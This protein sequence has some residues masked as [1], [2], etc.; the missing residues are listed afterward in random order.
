MITIYSHDSEVRF[1]TEINEGSRR[2]RTIGG[3]DY[4]LLKFSTVRPVGFAVGDYA[5]VPGE[6]RMT[7][8]SLPQPS[9]NTET[10]GYDYQLRLEPQW[11]LMRNRLLMLNPGAHAEVEFRLTDTLAGHMRMAMKCI[12]SCG[13][14]WHDPADGTDIQYTV[15]ISTDADLVAQDARLISYSSTDI[16]SGL[17]EM[18][19]VFECEVW[20]EGGVI[21]FGRREQGDIVS[22]ERGD[23]VSDIKPSGRDGS[24]PTRLYAFG[25][26]ENLPPYY[27]K[28][29]VFKATRVSGSDVYD[30]DHPLR[31]SMFRNALHVA[32]PGAVVK[33][34]NL[35][36]SG[37]G[38]MEAL[39]SS[40]LITA[41]QTKAG[42]KHGS[43]NV[44]LSQFRPYVEFNETSQKFANSK[45]TFHITFTY[46][47]ADGNPESRETVFEYS[48]FPH[49]GKWKASWQD[50]VISLPVDSDL[51]IGFYLT[52]HPAANAS[53]AVQAVSYGPSLELTSIAAY[54]SVQG[55]TLT[56]ADGSRINGV[57]FNVGNN[58]DVGVI[59]LRLPSGASL[60]VG[61][62]FTLDGLVR[63]NIPGSWFTPL[64]GEPVVDAVA[65]NRLRL[66]VDTPYIDYGG[67]GAAGAIEHVEIFDD[68]YPRQS[69]TISGVWSYDV[70]SENADG[71]RVT[72]RY[73]CIASGTLTF[74]SDFVIPGK[75]GLRI[76]FTSGLL[77]GM[78]F[79]AEWLPHGKLETEH[80]PAFE[81]VVN[82]D[83]G[84][85][86]PNTV[87]K[88]AENDSFLLLG[89]ADDDVLDSLVAAAELELKTKAGEWM[90][91]NITNGETY[92]CPMVPESANTWMP[93][94]GQRI[95]LHEASLFPS[96]TFV[97]RVIGLDYALDIPYD[98]P[99]VTVGERIPAKRLEGIEERL[100]DM[101][102][103]D[104]YSI[105]EPKPENI[106]AAVECDLS[107]QS[108]MV[109]FND[110]G[111][112][113]G[114]LPSTQVQMWVDGYRFHDYTVAV[115]GDFTG[116]GLTVAGETVAV[117]S[118]DLSMPA[119]VE[120][121]VKATVRVGG[122]DVTRT[123]VF[124]LLRRRG[125]A[126][127]QLLPSDSKIRILSDGSLLPESGQ[128]T[129]GVL[130][131]GQ[132]EPRELTA[133]EMTDAGLEVEWRDV[134]LIDPTDPDGGWQ[135]GTPAYTD[136]SGAV[137]LRLMQEGVCIDLETV[138]LVADGRDGQSV[139]LLDLDNEMDSVPCDSDAN[140]VPASYACRSGIR[141][142][143]GTKDDTAS[144]AFSVDSTYGC[145]ASI[146]TDGRLV[147]TGFTEMKC[148]AT[149]V[150]RKQG[151]ADLY[152]TM[153][154]NKVM[155]E[156]GK[157]PVIYSIEPTASTISL[158]AA[159]TMRPA[160]I[161]ARVK[162]VKGNL[163]QH[164][165][166]GVVKYLLDDDETTRT[167]LPFGSI[168]GNTKRITPAATT[169]SVTFELYDPLGTILLDTER[170]PVVRDG[171][172]GD[173]T[174]DRGPWTL[175]ESY[176]AG[177][178]NPAT[179]K[180]EISDAWRFGSR[181]RC[182]VTAVAAQNADGSD[183]GPGLG[184]GWKFISGAGMKLEWADSVTQICLSQIDRLDYTKTVVVYYHGEDVTDRCDS[185]VWGRRTIDAYG[186]ERTALDAAW[187]AAQEQ[188]PGTESLRLDST[189]L[190]LD[191]AGLSGLEIWCD[192]ELT[193]PDI[194][195]AARKV[196]RRIT[197]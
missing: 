65:S 31:L 69:N 166:Y 49:T 93:S 70:Q 60:A 109:V 144:W 106:A 81:I 113:V 59:P 48:Y 86:L 96:G 139:Y 193:D 121:P 40:T 108:D 116:I 172:D 110:F 3:D 12:A 159:G 168:P 169:T 161:G 100:R 123:M 158:D 183:N 33:F 142:F 82:D 35:G 132:G 67:A 151:C 39:P 133:Q 178:V 30:D 174:A 68:V 190:G 57:A 134:S 162:A 137:Q 4:A 147:M 135:T 122:R 14:T 154:A 20:I 182:P 27:R 118:A 171:S 127:F 130:I 187:N 115:E 125:D 165:N 24:R 89:W 164:L 8:A 25:G 66:P 177:D 23:N 46:T 189:T 29:M 84:R 87:L 80:T 196:R 128:L 11:A 15:D 153:K 103:I 180:P 77:N 185:F 61:D 186:N 58:P 184:K 105:P 1:T 18:A 160:T 117:T 88:P 78:T 156:G 157:P 145:S 7:V 45:A 71:S 76:K 143:Y 73:Y 140:P 195:G 99:V 90:E 179:G 5:D 94:L 150:A 44:R 148:T 37:G 85:R 138:P 26:T 97:S 101:G 192:V 120:I 53:G 167:V 119:R 191:S 54:D 43:Y 74:D 197:T 9:Y 181:W 98:N 124:T 62:T 50:M 36:R 173:I 56:K 38:N 41:T 104:D 10:G 47:G 136:T 92:D 22:F 75:E 51:T 131:S 102:R 13:F 155:G 6:G 114:G 79:A 32:D 64:D 107:N 17:R 72:E 129:C 16:L 111:E 194:A 91:T 52:F 141:V 163:M 28:K 42:L 152:A 126:R 83:F 21:H 112:I 63:L 146:D 2:V 95:R 19:S 34:D 170:V 149:V 188:T 175:G 55:I 176:F